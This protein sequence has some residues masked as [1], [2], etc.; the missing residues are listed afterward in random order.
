MPSWSRLAD[1]FLETE[2]RGIAIPLPVVSA[3]QSCGRLSATLAG[4]LLVASSFGW[5]LVLAVGVKIAYDLLVLAM[6][7]N[8]PPPG[9]KAIT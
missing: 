7:R 6:F 5:P 3:A 4:S 9:E 2:R 1:S 8:L